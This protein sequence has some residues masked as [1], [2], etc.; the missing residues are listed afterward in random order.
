VGEQKM[1]IDLD[2]VLDDLHIFF[3]P[4][5]YYGFE[6]V[7]SNRLIRNWLGRKGSYINHLGV[8]MD[9]TT[10]ALYED[11]LEYRTPGTL[12]KITTPESSAIEDFKDTWIKNFVP[13]TLYSKI[14]K[15]LEFLPVSIYL[16]DPKNFSYWCFYNTNY[17]WSVYHTNRIFLHPKDAMLA[18]LSLDIPLNNMVYD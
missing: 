10:D 8:T 12:V 13:I 18:R 9:W 17:P 7:T 11:D 2:A 3:V 15:E 1:I 4:Q 5:I 6:N 16:D 14:S